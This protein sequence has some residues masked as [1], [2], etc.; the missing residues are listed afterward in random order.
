MNDPQD[1]L[2]IGND[3]TV[4]RRVER[5]EQVCD[6]NLGRRRPTTQAFLQDGRNG[7]V[8]VS[9]WSETTPDDVAK[10]GDQPYQCTVSVG[11]LRENGLGIIRSPESGGPG[12]CDI[13]GRKT[14]GRLK[15]IVSQTQWVPGYAPPPGPDGPA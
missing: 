1:D 14:K 7:L 15:S 3:E 4:I 12:H 8:S 6:D 13:T 2:T 9:L 11:V 10:E 5:R